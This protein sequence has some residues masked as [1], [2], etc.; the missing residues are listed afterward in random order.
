MSANLPLD[1]ILEGD[2]I[3]LL[4]GLPENSVD[5]VFADP[6]YN[7]QLQNELRRPDNSL[8]MGSA[9]DGINSIVSP[10]MMPLPVPG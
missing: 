8:L 4:A 5:L 6:P 7:L 3:E 9:H 10:N 1:Q 2:C